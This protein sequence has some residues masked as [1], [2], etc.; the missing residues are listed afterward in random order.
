MGIMGFAMRTCTLCLSL[1]CLALVLCAPSGE[2]NCVSLSYGDSIENDGCLSRFLKDEQSDNKKKEGKVAST[3]V[4]NGDDVESNRFPYFALTLGKK[5]CGGLLIAPNIVMTAA[6]CEDNFVENQGVTLGIYTF[7]NK[8]HYETI[9]V[10]KK[11]PH[12][13]Y[14]GAPTH[15]NDFMIVVLQKSSSR[16]PVC[17]A[18]ADPNVGDGMTVIGYGTTEKGYT[19]KLQRADVQYIDNVECKAAHPTYAVTDSMMC[20]ASSEGKDACGGDSGGPLLALGTDADTDVALG[21]VSWGDECGEK[22]GVYGRISIV[23]DWIDRQVRENGGAIPERCR[24]GGE[25]ADEGNPVPTV[26]PTEARSASNNPT[27]LP[28]TNVPS[29]VPSVVPSDVSPRVPSGIPSDVPSDVPSAVPSDAPSGVPSPSTPK[30]TKMPRSSNSGSMDWRPAEDTKPE[31]TAKPVVSPKRPT[32]K[33]LQYIVIRKKKGVAVLDPNFNA[34]KSKG[35]P[36]ENSLKS[37]DL[38]TYMGRRSHIQVKINASR[39]KN[40][41]KLV[42]NKRISNKAQDLAIRLTKHGNTGAALEKSGPPGLWG[43]GWCAG[44]SAVLLAS[45]PVTIQ[46]AEKWT[47]ERSPKKIIGYQ[48]YRYL[49]IG[50]AGG[51]DGSFNVVQLLCSRL[52]GV[53]GTKDFIISKRKDRIAVVDPSFRGRSQK[54]KTWHDDLDA[55]DEARHTLTQRMN[56]FRIR[57]E[58]KRFGKDERAKDMAQRIAKTMVRGGWR[59]PIKFD[60]KSSWCAGKAVILVLSEPDLDGL[61]RTLL[62]SLNSNR[63]IAH[64][65]YKYIGIGIATENGGSYNAVQLLCTKLVDFDAS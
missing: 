19:T 36:D 21:V 37:Q 22:P 1:G 17:M 57:N 33:Q 7:N 45:G 14:K 34:K 60:W 41:R 35:A 43:D 4:V 59:N 54:T 48:K 40:A 52:V 44:R 55:N 25:W 31:V 6:H 15:S 11:I 26:D 32:I 53:A 8:K 28:P 2:H 18:S 65:S 49:G 39:N 20:A 30:P 9:K 16:I 12:P 38:N 61:S 64:S 58:I 46:I 50:V 29:D 24:R 5:R 23:R 3:R 56:I 13:R 47:T 10:K 62:R 27:S 42:S 63:F 51:P